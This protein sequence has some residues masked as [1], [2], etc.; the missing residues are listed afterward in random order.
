MSPSPPGVIGADNRPGGTSLPLAMPGGGM[1]PALGGSSLSKTGN[2]VAAAVISAARR[3]PIKAIFATVIDSLRSFLP[4]PPRGELDFPVPMM[5]PL[6]AR[7]GV[8]A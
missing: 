1:A 6:S 4:G 2:T 7:P 3:V 5:T 8:R